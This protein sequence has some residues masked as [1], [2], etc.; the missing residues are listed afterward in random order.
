MSNFEIVT[1]ITVGSI[2][3]IILL[4]FIVLKRKG[5]LT[6]ETKS[7]T[8]YL[9]PNPQCRKVFEEPIKLT[10]LSQKPPRVFLGCPH[11]GIDMEKIPAISAEKAK[12]EDHDIPLIKPV[13]NGTQKTQPPQPVQ[14]ANKNTLD[15]KSVSVQDPPSPPILQMPPQAKSPPKPLPQTL[16]KTAE[17][18]HKPDQKKNSESL[19]A[20]KHYLG[21]VKTLPKST[22]IPDECMWCTSIVKC[23]TGTEKIEA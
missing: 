11:C 23:L 4:Y 20:C 5:W 1:A 8:S 14:P 10:D 6:E 9:C 12:T 18:N 2:G 3:A 19:K 7:V 22:P 21:Y 17:I 15:V 16:T 13:I